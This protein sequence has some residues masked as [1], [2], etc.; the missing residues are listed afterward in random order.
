MLEATKRVLLRDGF[1]DAKITDVAE[2]AGV[3]P[4]SLYQ[5]F[6]SLE[7]LVVALHVS[8]AEAEVAYLADNLMEARDDTPPD[9]AAIIAMVAI[10]VRADDA[11]LYRVLIDVAPRIGADRK[12][13]PAR[14]EMRSLLAGFLRS[15]DDVKAPNLNVASHIVT[16]ALRAAIES[17]LRTTPEELTSDAFAEELRALVYGYLWRG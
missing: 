16:V 15:R 11:E 9:L 12:L 6:P 1:D 2:V 4:G 5:Y 14:K 17:T 7:S 3:S 8:L 13:E 10:R